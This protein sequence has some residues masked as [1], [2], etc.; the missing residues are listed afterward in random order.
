MDQPLLEINDLTKIFGKGL[1]QQKSQVV[2]LQHFSAEIAGTPAKIVTIAGESGS[3]KSTL[4]NSILGFMKCTFG[5]IHFKGQ[6]VSKFTKEEI[7]RYRRE[8]QA[9]FQ[10][11]YSVYNPF[12]CVGHIFDIAFNNFHLASNDQDRRD[13][14]EE[15]LNLVGLKG[16]E[17][18]S[19]YPHQLSGGQLQRLMIARA[20]M[21]KPSLIIADEPVSMIDVSLRAMILE[22]MVKLK[23]EYGI[24]FIYITHDFSTAYQISDEMYL[25]YHGM[26]V[27]KGDT[28]KIINNPQH[29]YTKKLIASIPT[30]EEKWEGNIEISDTSV[31]AQSELLPPPLFTEVEPLHWAV[32]T[33]SN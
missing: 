11:P 22:I 16:E 32:L 4:A 30:I 29:P 2:A 13:L 10:D 7:F 17:V 23:K 3:G 5:T 8:V 19:K 33:E 15:A 12:Y 21:L 26:T 25:L 20:Y 1:D 24:S 27:E 9:V 14:T 6:D 28:V 18:L 31:S